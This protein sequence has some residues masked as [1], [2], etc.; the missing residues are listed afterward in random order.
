[1]V[2][3]FYLNRLKD[4][5]EFLENYYLEILNK[6][7][8]LNIYLVALAIYFRMPDLK[9][10]SYVDVSIKLDPILNYM[11]ELDLIS[12]KFGNEVKT[13]FQKNEVKPTLQELYNEH[14]NYCKE[15]KIELGDFYFERSLYDYVITPIMKELKYPSYNLTGDQDASN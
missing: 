2:N 13:L 4:K 3:K 11:L 12:T 10:A 14:V 5:A 1:M 15:Q 9:T 8:K 6:K 7:E